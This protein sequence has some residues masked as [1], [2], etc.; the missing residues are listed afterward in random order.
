MVLTFQ[1]STEALRAQGLRV[2]RDECP[3][4]HKDVDQGAVGSL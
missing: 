1:F 3:L 4:P 2:L